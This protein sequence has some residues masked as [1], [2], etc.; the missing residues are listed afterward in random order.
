MLKKLVIS[1]LVTLGMS[2]A[3]NAA[4]LTFN[5]TGSIP[6]V[7]GITGVTIGATTYEASFHTGSYNSL[8]LTIDP[9]AVLL[10]A[11]LA[12]TFYDYIG[13]TRFYG[14]DYD[15]SGCSGSDSGSVTPFCSIMTPTSLSSTLDTFNAIGITLTEDDSPS[16]FQIPLSFDIPIVNLLTYAKWNEVSVSPVPVP[17]A[18]FMFAPALLGFLGFRRKLRA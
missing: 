5:T 17:A 2:T 8:G 10:N 7:T 13:G 16:T 9:N 6:E 4:T 12:V 15:V 14:T 11:A 18:V 1:L 3:L